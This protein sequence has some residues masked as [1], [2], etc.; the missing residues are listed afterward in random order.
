MKNRPSGRA[1]FT[2]IQITCISL[3]SSQFLRPP[4]L[5]APSQHQQVPRVRSSPL[6]T[7]SD[8]SNMPAGDA[9]GA[10]NP[11]A[12]PF[13]PLASSQP[14]FAKQRSQQSRPG[15]QAERCRGEHLPPSQDQVTSSGTRN[16]LVSPLCPMASPHSP[17]NSV[18]RFHRTARLLIMC[19]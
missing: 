15:S 1:R 5:I 6:T 2:T 17:R 18:A 14:S 19:M 10:M 11:S 7:W 3:R 4:P 8:Q 12:A 9:N 13:I 16:R